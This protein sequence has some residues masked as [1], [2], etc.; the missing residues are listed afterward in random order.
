[1]ILF[2]QNNLGDMV[3]LESIIVKYLFWKICYFGLPITLPTASRSAP[4][5]SEPFGFLGGELPPPPAFAS[6]QQGP[7]PPMLTQKILVEFFGAQRGGII[8]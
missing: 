4:S 8:C 1:M 7:P 3:L 5:D 2:L 6:L